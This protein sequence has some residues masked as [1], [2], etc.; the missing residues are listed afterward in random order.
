MNQE[1]KKFVNSL[2]LTDPNYPIRDIAIPS[3]D[4]RWD[5]SKYDQHWFQDQYLIC[6]K[7]GFKAGDRRSSAIR[8]PLL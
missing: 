1:A 6:I 2:H 5:Y 4:P 7:A 8:K 3:M